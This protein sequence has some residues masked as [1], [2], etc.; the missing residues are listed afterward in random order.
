MHMQIVQFAFII[1]VYIQVANIANA[2]HAGFIVES[3]MEYT[4]NFEIFFILVAAHLAVTLGERFT[5]G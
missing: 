5:H 2:K 3:E 4:T 1:F